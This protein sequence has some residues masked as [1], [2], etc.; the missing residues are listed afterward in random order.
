MWINKPIRL[1]FKIGEFNLFS[2]TFPALVLNAH[3]TKLGNRPSQLK[4][5]LEKLQAGLEVLVVRSHPADKRMSRVTFSRKCIRYVPEQYRRYYID[6]QGTF[7]EYLMTFSSKSRATLKRKVRKFSEFSGEQSCAREF[8]TRK[9]MVEFYK[10]ARKVSRKTYQERLLDSGLPDNNE[11]LQQILDLA[12][13]DAAR[14]FILFL[15]SKPIAYL[16]CPALEDVLLYQYLG[17]DPEFRRW[18]PGNVLQYHALGR[19][20]AES[21]FK[22]LDFTEGEGQHKEFFA[23]GNINCADIYYFRRTFRNFILLGLHS[24]INVISELTPMILDFLGVKQRV[25]RFIR[26][27]A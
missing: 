20:F 26:V 14:G 11:F 9:D 23:N 19:I 22:I 15:K 24:V 16:F 17:Y 4:T 25:K 18:S 13:H 1:K 21:K 10:L 5:P 8:K 2:M 3:F 27:K 12:T 7:D 6:L